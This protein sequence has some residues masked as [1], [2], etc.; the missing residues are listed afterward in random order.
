MRELTVHDLPKVTASKQEGL[1]SASRGV[2]G[3][4]TLGSKVNSLRVPGMSSPIAEAGL[5]E[6]FLADLA[7]CDWVQSEPQH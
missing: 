1:L 2:M 6:A 3:E 7:A 5:V 4:E